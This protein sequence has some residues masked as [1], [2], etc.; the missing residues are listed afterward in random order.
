MAPVENCIE[1]QLGKNGFQSPSTCPLP[2]ALFNLCVV[3]RFCYHSNFLCELEL[4]RTTKLNL[5]IFDIT[6]E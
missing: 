1:L 3:A 6:T 4:T 5:F 2:F